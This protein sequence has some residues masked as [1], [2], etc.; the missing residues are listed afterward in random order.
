MLRNGNWLSK[1]CRSHASHLKSQ[2]GVSV[3]LLEFSEGPRV[4]TDDSLTVCLVDQ[5]LGYL[6]K[7]FALR[8]HRNVMVIKFVG[9]HY[10]FK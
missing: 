1:A 3:L 4:V 7:V 2:I 9:F 8:K 6:L 5:V 10:L